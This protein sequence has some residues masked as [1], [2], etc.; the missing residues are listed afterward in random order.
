M[1]FLKSKMAAGRHFEK[2]YKSNISET[3]CPIFT[4]FE[5]E[6]R[7]GTPET[8]LGSKM[9][10]CE[11]QDDRPAPIEIYKY[12]NNIETVSPKWI[13]FG[14]YYPP[15]KTANINVKN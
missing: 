15:Y 12:C 6:L 10:F 11:I 14:T 8:T 4:K 2:H 13:K 9:K 3:V 5:P 1:E 7:L